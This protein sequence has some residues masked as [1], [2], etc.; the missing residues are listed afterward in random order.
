MAKY[1]WRGSYTAEGSKAILRD[2]GTKRVEAVVHTVAGLGGKVEAFYFG[3]GTDDFYVVVDL[4]D[5][6][7]AASASLTMC[8]S[9]VASVETVA[10]LTPEELDMAATKIVL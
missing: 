10:L 2:G 6:A 7:T 4:P 3:F 5:N 8:A 9:G 1:L